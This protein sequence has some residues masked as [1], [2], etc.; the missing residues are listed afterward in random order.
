[1]SVATTWGELLMGEEVA[2]VSAEPARAARVAALPEGLHPH[3]SESLERRGVTALYAHQAEAWEAASRGEHLVVTTGTASGKT[4]AFNLPV[5]DAIARDPK[6]RAL[7]LYPTKALAQDQARSL[8]A[9]GVSGVRPAIY[10]GDTPA[11]QRSQIRSWANADPHESGHAA[12][13][14]S[15]LT[16]TAGAT[17]SRTS[18]TSSSMRRT[19]T[20]GCSGLTSGTSCGACGGSRGVYGAEPQFLLASATIAN[21]SELAR[22]LT[23]L[24]TTVVSDDAAPRAERT[25]LLWNPPLLD[26]ELNLRASALGEAARIV[27]DLVETWTA[28][29]LL[30]EE[31]Q[32]RG[33]D[34]PIH[35]RAP[36]TRVRRPALAVPRRLHTGATARYREAVGEW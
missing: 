32:G 23:G 14:R 35:R 28:H 18:P 33:A 27:A 24:D 19:C 31:P 4:L 12:P 21:P 8:G 22:E 1:M 2:H 11:G 29:A 26:V 17:C 5:L 34:P 25:V 10:D 9:L 3:V 20:G 36:G 13:R 15:C 6:T 7:Y 30:R 16:T